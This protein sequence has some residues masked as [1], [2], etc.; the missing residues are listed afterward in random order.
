MRAIASPAIER[1]A[2][3]WPMTESMLRRLSP[4]T[5]AS[6]EPDLGVPRSATALSSTPKTFSVE[7]E[8]STLKVSPFSGLPVMV[9]D[10]PS[11]SIAW[12]DT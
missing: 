11:N 6:A 5:C 4:I 7:V 1:A 12:P 10:M 2:C 9:S 3:S 8:G